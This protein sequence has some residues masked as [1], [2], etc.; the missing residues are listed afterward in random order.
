MVSKGKLPRPVYHGVA[1]RHDFLKGMPEVV[2]DWDE[3]IAQVREDAVARM[4]RGHPPLDAVVGLYTEGGRE[5]TMDD[6]HRDRVSLERGLRRRFPK[7]RWV[8]TQRTIHR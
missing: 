4:R 3:I 7:E 5:R 6:R 2:W 8:I 1:G